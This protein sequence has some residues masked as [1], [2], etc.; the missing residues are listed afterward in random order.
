MVSEALEALARILEPLGC[1]C[2]ETQETKEKR[3]RLT[4][5]KCGRRYKRHK[6][7]F[8]FASGTEEVTLRVDDD[9]TSILWWANLEDK[10]KIELKDVREVKTKDD[11]GVT[12]LSLSGDLLL[13]LTCGG[14]RIGKQCD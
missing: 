9:A 7:T 11:L 6:K 1:T 14:G 2:I 4:M 5:L 12:V 3:R 13:E 10:K 8:G